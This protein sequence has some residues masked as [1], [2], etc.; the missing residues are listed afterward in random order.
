MMKKCKNDIEKKEKKI[1][2]IYQIVLFFSIIAFWEL[3]V[4]IGLIDSF[5]FSSPYEIIKLLFSY[6][7][8]CYEY[9]SCSNIHNHQ[10]FSSEIKSSP[11]F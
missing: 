4:R 3:F 9:L 11:R 10:K 6:Q 7:I 8:N 2:F 5:L 1:I